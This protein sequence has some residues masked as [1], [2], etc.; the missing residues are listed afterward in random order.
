MDIK[1][2][3]LKVKFEGMD[4]EIKYPTVKQLRE[5]VVK[6]EGESDTD[7]TFRFLAELGLPVVTL[8]DMEPENIKDIIDALTGQKKS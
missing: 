5:L 8:E 7:M 2:R 4:F 1:K 6:K 3:V